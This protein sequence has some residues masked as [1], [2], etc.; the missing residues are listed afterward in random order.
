[1]VVNEVKTHTD[2]TQFDAIELFN[3]TNAAVDISGWYLS[4]SGDN[5][6][7]YQIPA[8]TILG[9][10]QYLVFDETDFNPT[11]ATPL[12]HHF[13]LN[14]SAGDEVYLS[15][16]LSPGVPAL[17]DMISFDATF[18]GQTLARFPNATGR[19]LP[20]LTPSLGAADA[21]PQVGPLV[22]S[23]F[24]YNPALPSA[25]ALAIVPTMT[26]QQ[27]EFV[28]IKNPTLQTITLT[29]WRLRGQL[30]FDFAPGTTMLPGETL[31][32]IKFDPLSGRGLGGPEWVVA[33]PDRAGRQRTDGRAPG[34][35][36]AQVQ[37][38]AD[39]VAVPARLR[40]RPRMA[41][42][43]GLGPPR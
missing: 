36:A 21:N 33:G 1:M 39:P 8:N 37:G 18:N 25:A 40:P 12:A 26:R 4:D 13:A 5:P 19:L 23:E 10:G 32:V 20:S 16:V 28:E 14:G 6:L 3:P 34:G 29:N 24:N 2:P 30:D 41:P 42:G 9:P 43:D 31:V 27:L 22:I 11:P 35:S 15:R 7:K 17:E 38:G